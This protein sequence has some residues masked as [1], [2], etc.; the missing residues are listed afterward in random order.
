M[1]A[2][3][4]QSLITNASFTPRIPLLQYNDILLKTKFLKFVPQTQKTGKT[5]GNLR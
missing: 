1:V 3:S 4:G 5:K 2:Y